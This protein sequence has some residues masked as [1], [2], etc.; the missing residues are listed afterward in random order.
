MA[1][2][3]NPPA[4]HYR[5]GLEPII[6]AGLLQPLGS[7]LLIRAILAQD[8]YS[9]L[10]HV[11]YKASDAECHEVL[12]VGPDVKDVKPGQHVFCRSTAADR[13]ANNLSCRFWLVDRADL[14]AV[15][16]PPRL[17]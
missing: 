9:A 16:D 11:D 3:G 17:G 15:W 12:A 14:R 4:Y 7:T 8:S 13:I 6:A 1:D 2:N 5:Q 10:A